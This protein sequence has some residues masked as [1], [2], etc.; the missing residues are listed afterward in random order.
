MRSS[1]TQSAAVPSL[2]R[3]ESFT[4]WKGEPHL[5]GI[6]FVDYGGVSAASRKSAPCESGEIDS[7]YQTV[8]QTMW[9]SSTAWASSRRRSTTSATIVFRTNLNNKPFDDKRVRNAL[10]LAVDNA[11]VLQARLQRR[12]H[13]W[14]RTITSARSI[15]NTTIC[16]RCRATWR[17]PRP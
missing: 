9:R 3:R 13:A 1:N 17:R 14:A 8:G 10:Q 4:W 16:R 15:P 2:K 5:D 6:E 12:G 7:N 11:T